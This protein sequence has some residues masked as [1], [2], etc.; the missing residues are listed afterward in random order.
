MDSGEKFINTM[1]KR[2]IDLEVTD[3]NIRDLV[4]WSY[5]TQQRRYKNPDTIKLGEAR[6]IANY[7]GFWKGQNMTVLDNIFLSIA[8]FGAGFSL[9][10]IITIISMLIRGER[11]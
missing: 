5:Q 4:G 7:L 6:K 8:A 3:R 9:V 2:Q 1:R 10:V 11:L